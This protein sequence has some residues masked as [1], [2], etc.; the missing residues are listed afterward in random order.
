VANGCVCISRDVIFD[1]NN[2]PFSELHPNARAQLRAEILLLHPM[3]HNSYGTDIVADH[4]AHGANPGAEHGGVQ[5]EEISAGDEISR[6][7]QEQEFSAENATD[8]QDANDLGVSASDQVPRDR[9]ASGPDCVPSLDMALCSASS[10][11]SVLPGGSRTDT[12]RATAQTLG[13]SVV[14]SGSVVGSVENEGISHAVAHEADGDSSVVC[15]APTRPCTCLQDN[16]V[17]AKIF[18]DGTIRYDRLGMI[19]VREPAT[20]HEALSDEN[21]KGAMDEEFL[22]LMKN[23]T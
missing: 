13:G 23:R 5:V 1:E 20:L 17:K 2:F 10:P 11:G 14:P 7:W 22:A 9:Q 6:E 19:T 21:W 4:R 12:S 16:I 8:P 18:S 3:L 15:P